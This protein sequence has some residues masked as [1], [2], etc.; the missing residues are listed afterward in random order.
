MAL[1]SGRYYIF[2][3]VDDTPV[4]RNYIEDKSL[5]PKGIYKLPQ[6]I[7]PPEW[8]VEKLPNGNYKFQNR[9]ALVGA[10]DRNLFAFLIDAE[11]LFP[12]TEW[13]VQRDERD[14]GRDSYVITKAGDG[15]GWVATETDAQD[16]AQGPSEPPFFPPNEVFVFRKVD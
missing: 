11:G 15:D 2:S 14:A 10:L 8:D 1:E 7:P 16:V 12:T 4:G 6:G 9:G 5:L 3:K 13:T